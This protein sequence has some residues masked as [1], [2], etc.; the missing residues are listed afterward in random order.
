MSDK[1]GYF[2]PEIPVGVDTASLMA[3]LKALMPISIQGEYC[4]DEDEFAALFVVDVLKGFCLA[5][6]GPLAPPAPDAV[7]DSVISWAHMTARRFDRATEKFIVVCRECHVPNRLELPFPRHCERDSIEAQL[8]DKLAWLEESA[9]LHVS[10]ECFNSWIGAETIEACGVSFGAMEASVPRRTNIIES[11]INDNKIRVAVVV[12]V[13]TDI[14]D[15]QLVQS[16]LSARN[17]GLLPTLRDV[18]VEVPSC[19][20]YDLPLEVCRALDLP[21]SAA[22]PR[23]PFHHIGLNLMMQS[24]AILADN[25]LL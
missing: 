22:H 21:E 18:V 9:D 11:F 8:V 4:I 5:G 20:T 16:L 17:A 15:L 19:T 2:R 3:N 1:A 6:C 24:G 14:C 7:V 23:E 25:I 13:C 10:K 12:G